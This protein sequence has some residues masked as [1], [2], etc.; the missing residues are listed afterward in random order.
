MFGDRYRVLQSFDSDETIRP[1]GL[2][3]RRSN[4]AEWDADDMLLLVADQDQISVQSDGA[5]MW[6]LAADFGKAVRK[7]LAKLLTSQCAC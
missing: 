7:V 4:S 1:A 5:I 3:A 6:Q 2:V